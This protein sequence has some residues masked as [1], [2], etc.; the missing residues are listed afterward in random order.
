MSSTL[1]LE[2]EYARRAFD[3]L[4]GDGECVCGGSVA[5]PCSHCRAQEGLEALKE[6]DR[7]IQ[8]ADRIMRVLE[9][10]A[11]LVPIQELVKIKEW[12]ADR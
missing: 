6:V 8:E 3:N 9:R 10:T 2:M 4:D 7:Y 5:D 11:P 1:R 12:L